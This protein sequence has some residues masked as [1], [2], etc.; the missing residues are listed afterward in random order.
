MKD[1]YDFVFSEDKNTDCT[2]SKN[3][4]LDKFFPKNVMNKVVSDVNE[5]DVHRNQVKLKNPSSDQFRCNFEVVGSLCNSSN[6][7]VIEGIET[8][9]T[10]SNFYAVLWKIWKRILKI[11][12][13]VS[14]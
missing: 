4:G 13:F 12:S 11:I 6:R 10:A 8:L 5:V 2:S 7:D 3:G 14:I 1:L 9:T